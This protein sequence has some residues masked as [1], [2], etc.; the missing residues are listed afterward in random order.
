MTRI[1][2]GSQTE[3]FIMARTQSSLPSAS[4]LQSIVDNSNPL[5]YSTGNASLEQTYE[6]MLMG[7][8]NRA[9]IEKNSSFNNF[10][11]IRSSRNY[12][13]NATYISSADSVLTD[14]IVLPAGSQLNQPI[15]V[16]GYWNVSDNV[17]WS[18]LISPLSTNLNLGLGSVICQDARDHQQPGKCD[19][20]L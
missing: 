4:Q 10:L 14:G 18:Y 2:L 7:R 1:Q 20:Y 15:N 19:E 13:T 16:N 12:I 11:M 6:A 8:I 5:F 17:V 9:N 3:A